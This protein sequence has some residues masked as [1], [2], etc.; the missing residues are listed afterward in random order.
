MSE[1]EQMPFERKHAPKVKEL[2]SLTQQY[3]F[4]ALISVG[5]MGAVY[6]A[7]QVSLDRDVAIKVL[8]S[9]YSKDKV[10]LEEFKNEAQIIAKLNHH[11]LVSI[12]DFGLM[13]HF[14]YL[15]MEYACG[16]SLEKFIESEL[17]I[18][19]KAAH[20]ILDLC[21]G[22]K[23]A[24][25][26][27]VVHRD[28]K[29]ANIILTTDGDVKLVDFGIARKRGY[30]PHQMGDKVMGTAG[31]AAPEVT[32]SPEHID[33]RSDVYAI[34]ATICRL[35]TGHTPDTLI[36]DAIE[37][38]YLLGPLYP[39]VFQ[40][41]RTDP[42]M[43]Y[44]SVEDLEAAIRSALD[45]EKLTASGRVLEASL[46]KEGDGETEAVFTE[47]SRASSFEEKKAILSS[48]VESATSTEVIL[49]ERYKLVSC[50]AE[51][52]RMT[53]YKAED[54]LMSRDVNVRLFFRNRERKWANDF[55][56]LLGNLSC[57]EHPNIPKIFDGGLHKVGAFLLYGSLNGDNISK[58]VEEG[59]SAKQTCNMAS[60]IL[61][62]LEVSSHYGFN[63]YTF[64][65]FSIIREDRGLLPSRYLLTDVGVTE[66]LN[67]IHDD[68][69]NSGNVPGVCNEWCAP[70]LFFDVPAGEKTTIYIF[71]QLLISILSGGHPWVGMSI[72][73]IMKKHEAGERIDLSG[74][75]DQLSDE[76][77]DWLS[78]M[79]EP[80]VEDRFA[81]IRE[82]RLAIPS[83]LN[84]YGSGS[85]KEFAS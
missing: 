19:R 14:P 69:S 20:I 42:E 2:N 40:C 31:F 24:H 65:S 30:I 8:P 18:Y 16:P 44:Q 39:I 23:H 5:G 57:V 22:I 78:R 17:I 53:V 49:A 12:H 25:Q 73:D 64:N 82:A 67:L 85:N 50:L 55:M 1:Y 34:G 71:G 70:E 36:R 13:G 56:T 27:E 7:K 6:L 72:F 37:R 9:R 62:A 43:R 52:S 61:D 59:I 26:R 68:T 75:K 77:I 4:K 74:L 32:E 10:F 41:I 48:S 81:S 79:S 54:L 11:N 84:R 46:I 15:V 45:A 58:W 80:K 29:P 83:N 33:R 28:I 51:G 47:D 38:R 35:V 60:Q 76:F 3:A 21:T 63:H 66:V